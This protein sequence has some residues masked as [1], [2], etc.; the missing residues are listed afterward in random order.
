MKWDRQFKHNLRAVP[1]SQSWDCRGYWERILRRQNCPSR[2]KRKHRLL[3]IL[4]PL[5][6]ATG[7][8]GSLQTEV[9]SFH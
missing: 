3:G 4:S 1:I 8:T 2:W 6:A 7:V 5:L 9:G